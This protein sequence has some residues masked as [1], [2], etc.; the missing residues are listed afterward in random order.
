MGRP[1]TRS[2]LVLVKNIEA[3]IFSTRTHKTKDYFRG[4]IRKRKSGST[5]PGST[6]GLQDEKEEEG[7]ERQHEKKQKRKTYGRQQIPHEVGPGIHN[8]E[9]G[10][11]NKQKAKETA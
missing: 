3:H 5:Q 4:L 1:Y 9:I 6:K 2:N 8:E 7:K 10:E 11:G